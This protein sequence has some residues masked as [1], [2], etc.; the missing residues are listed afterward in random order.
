MHMPLI[1]SRRRFPFQVD[2]AI[3]NLLVLIICFFVALLP[4]ISMDGLMNPTQTGKFTFFLYG[5]LV[6][7]GVVV[8][9]LMGKRELSVGINLLDIVL[10]VLLAYVSANRFWI[11]PFYGFSLKYFELLGLSVLYIVFKNALTKSF[12]YL[13]LAVVAGGML[14][15]VYGAFQLWG[16]YDSPDSGFKMTGSFSNPGPYAGFLVAVFPVALGIYLFRKQCMERPIFNKP[17]SVPFFNI[18][19]TESAFDNI[20]QRVFFEYLPFAGIL[21]MII[22]LP[23]TQS[24][25]TWLAIAF[26]SVFLLNGRYQYLSVVRNILDKGW[27]K[28]LVGALLLLSV[29]T[30]GY[31]LYHYRQ[32]SADGRLLIWKVTSRM[33]SNN[34]WTGVGYDRFKANYMDYQADY[35]KQHGETGEEW[36]AGDTYY[37]FNEL[38]ELFSELGIIGISLLAVLV[39]LILELATKPPIGY[40]S[41]IALSGLLSI[42]TFG[43]FSYPG[44]ILPIKVCLTLYVAVL[45]SKIPLKPI[46]SL[47]LTPRLKGVL[48]LAIMFI[49][50]FTAQAGGRLTQA[51]KDWR[52]AFRSYQD[53]SYAES[54]EEYEKLYPSLKTNGEYLMNYGKALSMVGKHEEAVRMLKNARKYYSST[55]IETTS[56]DSY[57]MLN[58]YDKAE[59]HYNRALDMIPSRFYPTYLLVKLY[60]ESG[61]KEAAI[62]EAK[63]LLN[64][65]VKVHSI[66]IEE[67][68]LEMRKI[69]VSCK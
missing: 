68:K 62:H 3:S 38:L 24:R 69:I 53:G 36:V 52:E 8:I 49:I 40:L 39:V 13:M 56:G 54:V 26:S 55:I 17:I 4:S 10:F 45:F 2:Q 5:M 6:I 32:G 37:A 51:Q 31:G 14:Q 19:I 28:L 23:S 59:A 21:S 18:R 65:D 25:A 22:V 61:D 16:Y 43:M 41:I 7:V 29:G 60:Q 42:I 57:K 12:I 67:I 50:G 47:A 20:V 64:R 58:Q 11:Q 15:A 33:I 30:G 44:E 66:A 48:I 9:W 46:I 63:R 35:F 34:L 1:E 27:K